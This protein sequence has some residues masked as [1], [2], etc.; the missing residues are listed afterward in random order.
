MY[1]AVFVSA[2]SV[3]II[4]ITKMKVYLRTVFAHVRFAVK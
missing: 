3:I 1:A 4:I 2:K